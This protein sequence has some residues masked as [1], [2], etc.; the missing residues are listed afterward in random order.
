[1]EWSDRGIVLSA[2]RHGESA[3]I[4]SLLTRAH[5]RHAGLARGGAGRRARG[6]YQ[7]GNLLSAVWR[8]R[9]PDHLGNYSCEL[10][11]AWAADFLDDPP[12]LAGLAAA[13]ALTDA[14]LP[15]REPHPRLFDSLSALLSAPAV[16]GWFAAHVHW[17]VALLADLGFGLDLGSCAATGTTDDLAYVSPKSGRAVSRSAA[18]PYREKLLVLPAFLIA[19]A[20]PAPGLGDLLAG[21]RLTG[22]FLE[23]F[24]FAPLE[25]RLPP[26]RTRYIEGLKRAATKSGEIEAP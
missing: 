21:L 14:A 9:L 20:G 16:P 12:R 15:E 7:T 8:A 19:E 18:G 5:G 3:A 6:V 25:R 11:R 22:Y 26:A 24:V 4:V 1:M 13:C 17:E 10:A 2:R 23:R